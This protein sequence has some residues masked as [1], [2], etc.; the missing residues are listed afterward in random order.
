MTVGALGENQALREV[1][2]EARLKFDAGSRIIGT[3]RHNL[4]KYELAGKTVLIT[5]AARRMRPRVCAWCGQG[6]GNVI[7]HHG[8]SI[9]ERRFSNPRL[10]SWLAGSPPAKPRGVWQIQ[11]K[12]PSL[13]LEQP[14]SGVLLAGE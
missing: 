10:S 1:S 7:L 5:G 6:W 13:S 11:T 4:M 3:A 14:S 8:Q 2:K 12:P 9:N